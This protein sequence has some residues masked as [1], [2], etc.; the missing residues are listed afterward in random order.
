[1]QTSAYPFA[2]DI[3]FRVQLSAPREFALNLRI[4]A[5]AAGATL[6]IN[7]RRHPV[8]LMPGRFANIRRR[9]SSGDRVELEL[10]LG[11]RLEAIDAAHADTA[12][13]LSG[14]LVLFALT[15][16]QPALSRRQL[17]AASK[18]GLQSWEVASG[19]GPIRF[20]PFTVIGD[21]PYATYLKLS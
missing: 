18:T 5:W 15:S 12:A 4:P 2:G 11:V 20:L 8:A 14:P 10:P 17:L 13:L 16:A 9:W 1:M 19:G 21:Q 3:E 6:A 7:S